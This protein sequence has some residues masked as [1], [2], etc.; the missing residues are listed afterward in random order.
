MRRSSRIFILFSIASMI[1]GGIFAEN[2]QDVIFY[3]GFGVVCAL[4]SVSYAILS[5]RDK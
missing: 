2:L 5:L 4:F 1:M 3:V